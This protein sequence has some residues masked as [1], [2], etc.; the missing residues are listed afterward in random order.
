MKLFYV[1]GTCSVNPH[2]L[3]RE[4]GAEFKLD[5]VDRTSKMTDD[6]IDYNAINPK[7]YVP[8]LEVDGTVLTEGAAIS[9]YL[10]DQAG[11][12]KIA[13]KA[14]TMER[15]KMQ[16]WLVFIASELHKSYG[17][18]F[19]KTSDPVFRENLA[20]R[21]AIVEKHFETHQFLVGDKFS[22]ADSYL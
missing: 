8:A 5:K 21:L 3:L 11:G 2:I 13:P 4:M 6:G 7:S 12:E 10:A 19:R 15:Y 17:P 1:P 18:L 14:G 16:E 22:A 9:M 20:K